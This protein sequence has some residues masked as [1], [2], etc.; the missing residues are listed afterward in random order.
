M[1]QVNEFLGRVHSDLKGPFPRTRQSY[2][3]YISFLEESIGLIDIKPLKFKDDAL[4]TFKNYKALHEKQSGSLLKI[5]HTDGGPEYIEGFDDCL[6]KNGIS[7]E[8]T[9]SSSPEQNRKAERVNRTS[10]GPVRAI[11]VQ[12]RLPKSLWAEITKAVVYLQNQSPIRQGTTTIFEHLKGEI[13]Y[14]GHLHIL[15]YRVWVYILKRKR[16]K[17]DDRSY[18]DIHVGYEGTDQY[19]VYNP[20]SGRVSFTRDLHFDEAHLLLLLYHSL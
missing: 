17:L 7:H 9:A 5:L 20:Q 15:G 4:A 2:W 12:Q 1:Y 8:V 14:L 6:K 18:Q 11:F 19:R 16:K 3:Y 13:P 10:I